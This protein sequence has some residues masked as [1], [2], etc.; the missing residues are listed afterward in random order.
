[1]G[2]PSDMRSVVGRNFVMWCIPVLIQLF[3]GIQ[4]ISCVNH[5]EQNIL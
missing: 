4:V 5:S 3:K 1:M 2:S